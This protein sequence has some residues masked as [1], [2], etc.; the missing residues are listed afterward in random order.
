[1]TAKPNKIQ[2]SN[3]LREADLL[4]QKGDHAKA[5]GIFEKVLASDPANV[6]AAYNLGILHHQKGKLDEAE[7]YFNKALTAAPRDADTII[8]LALVVI[9]KGD[10]GQALKLSARACEIE[11][12]ARIL[13]KAGGIEREAGNLDAARALY[14]KAMRQDPLYTQAYAGYG[15]VQK[16]QPDSEPFRLLMGAAAKAGS[17][18]PPEQMKLGFILGKAYLD[19]GDAEKAFA[20]YAEANRLKRATYKVFSIEKFEAYADSIIRLFTPALVEKLKGAGNPSARPVFI[21]G[22]PRSGSTLTDQ[23]VSSHPQAASMGEMNFLQHSIPVFPNADVPDYFSANIPNVNAE[24]VTL[25]SPAMLQDIAKKYLAATDKFAGSSA[26]LVDKMLFNYLWVGLIRLALPNAK[27]I[28][29]TRDPIDMGLSIWQL[30]FQ[31]S[32]PW[33]YDQTEIGRYYKAYRKVMAHWEKLFPGDIFEANYE[34]MV[35]NQEEETRRLLEFCG[36][37]FDE[38]CL[39]FHQ[40][41]RKVSTASASQVRQPIYKDSVKK[42]KKYEKH[43]QPLIDAV[44]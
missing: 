23:I 3:A 42:W 20:H 32:I 28:H 44:N 30:S 24:L 43:L 4:L 37:P 25:L 8:S 19:A 15:A 11:P 27:I 22:M 34:T 16:F 2:I 35:V 7:R 6:S 1:M 9:D 38:A 39:N 40:S 41:T 31:G 29:C 5:Y 33:A 17:L 13:S 36:L 21:V 10:I 14:E 26:R 18:P 12:S